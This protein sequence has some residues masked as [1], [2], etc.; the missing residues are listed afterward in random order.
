MNAPA[1]ST[2]TTPAVNVEVPILKLPLFTVK[3][4][5]VALE[6]VKLLA[7]DMSV[8]LSVPAA[9]VISDE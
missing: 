7:N 3:L 2:V 5:G 1:E 9:N 4:C 6:S 8:V